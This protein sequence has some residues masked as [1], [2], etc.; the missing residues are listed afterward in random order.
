M[1]WQLTD[2]KD[3]KGIPVAKLASECIDPIPPW[4]SVVYPV[5]PL[6]DQALVTEL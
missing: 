4:N 6:D 3:E 1:I 2:K 5:E